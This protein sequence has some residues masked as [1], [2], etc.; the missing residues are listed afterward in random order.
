MRLALGAERVRL[1]RQLLTESVVLSLLGGILGVLLSF[2]LLA[3][4]RAAD[5]P[6]PIP[7]NEE[8]TIDGRVLAF[9]AVLSVLTGLLFGLAPALQGSRPDV[10]PILKNGRYVAAE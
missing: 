6:L 10:V 4:L 1:V 7:V 5:L 2:W 3:A 8:I 9:T